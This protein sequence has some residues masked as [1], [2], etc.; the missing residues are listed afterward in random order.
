MINGYGNFT[1][2]SVDA[3]LEGMQDNG[4]NKLTVAANSTKTFYYSFDSGQELEKVYFLGLM[5]YSDNANIG[6]SVTISTEYYVAPLTAWKRYKKFAKSFSVVPGHPNKEVLFP[7][8]PTY[9]VRLKLDY[10]NTGGS[11]VD[12]ICNLYNFNEHQVVDTASASEGTDW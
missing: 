11:P 10:K 4:S 3:R 12:F 1:D 2:S 8:T 5:I 9:G 7:T 6:D